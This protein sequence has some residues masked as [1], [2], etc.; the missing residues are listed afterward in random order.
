MYGNLPEMGT[1][2]SLCTII[3]IDNLNSTSVLFST[4]TSQ[5]DLVDI[6][7]QRRSCPANAKC[8]GILCLDQN[9]P[10]SWNPARKLAWIGW[11]REP[12]SKLPCGCGRHWAL[13][14]GRPFSDPQGL[15]ETASGHQPILVQAPIDHI[16][17]FP[18]SPAK[19][20]IRPEQ[21]HSSTSPFAIYANYQLTTRNSLLR[22]LFTCARNEHR[23]FYLF[24]S[25]APMSCWRYLFVQVP[26]LPSLLQVKSF[27]SETHA[28]APC[29]RKLT[30]TQ[31]NCLKL[32]GS[33]CRRFGW[34]SLCVGMPSPPVQIGP[35]RRR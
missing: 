28:T 25:S 23:E 29:R 33:F 34:G 30:E 22:G 14:A 5:E 4:T 8:S 17:P 31:N 7:Y 26:Y 24:L 3:R 11:S 12:Q 2:L 13:L 27:W 16:T 6:P 35:G 18:K 1:R 10:R 20:P 19:T 21:L 15:A 32:T 9:T